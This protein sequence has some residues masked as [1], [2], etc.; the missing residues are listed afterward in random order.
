MLKT[1]RSSDLASKELGTDEFVRGGGKANDRNPSKKSKNIKS[2]IQTNIKA[3][4]K[5]TFLTPVTK[6]TFY[7]LRQAFTEALILQ[8][9]DPEC[10]IRIQT[11]AS[12]YAMRRVLNQLTSDYLTFN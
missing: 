10:H 4:E 3:I 1:T 11:D 7:S 9:Y 2:G 12:S 6:E 8:H 5:S